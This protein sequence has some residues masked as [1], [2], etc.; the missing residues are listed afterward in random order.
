LPFYLPSAFKFDA[1]LDQSQNGVNL[2][3]L[4]LTFYISSAINR[5]IVPE[6]CWLS[7]ILA[8]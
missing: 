7:L 3:S 2:N 4:S 1:F 6:L 5:C 8:K